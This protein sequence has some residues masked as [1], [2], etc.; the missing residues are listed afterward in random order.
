M[1]ENVGNASGEAMFNVFSLNSSLFTLAY[2]SFYDL[3]CEMIF[4]CV[5]PDA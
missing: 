3:H 2:R 4:P 1:T 5:L